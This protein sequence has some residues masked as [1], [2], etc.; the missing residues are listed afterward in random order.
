MSWELCRQQSSDLWRWGTLVIGKEERKREA[1]QRC[2]LGSE[3]CSERL[4]GVNAKFGKP[5]KALLLGFGF[6]CC[7]CWGIVREGD[8]WLFDSVPF[9]LCEGRVFKVS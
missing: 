1:Q 3:K 4:R 5:L 9:L 8:T 6:F 7:F 2:G